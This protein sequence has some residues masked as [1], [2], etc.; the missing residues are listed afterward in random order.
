METAEEGMIISLV[1]RKVIIP[2]VQI[3]GAA[4]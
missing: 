4:L 2:S 3:N 1:G